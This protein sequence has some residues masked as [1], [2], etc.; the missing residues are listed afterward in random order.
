MDM[1]RDA[2]CAELLD[3]EVAEEVIVLREVLHVHDRR[4]AP[5]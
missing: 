1:E 3:E 4:G 2:A 5:F